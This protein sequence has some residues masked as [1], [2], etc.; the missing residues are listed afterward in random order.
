[1]TIFQRISHVAA[2]VV[3]ALLLG[4]NIVLSNMAAEDGMSFRVMA[5]YRWIFS[6][7]FLGPMARSSDE[8]L[9]KQFR[10]FEAAPHDSSGATAKKPPPDYCFSIGADAD[11][12]RIELLLSQVKGKDI[13]ELI[14]SGR[15]K[16]ALVP[17]GSGGAVA[18]AAL[19]GGAA[20]APAA[21]EK[22]KEKRNLMRTWASVSSIKGMLYRFLSE[23]LSIHKLSGKEKVLG[24]II[25][26]IGS[27]EKV[28]NDYPCHYTSTAWMSLMG[29]IQ[30]TIFGLCFERKSNQWKLGWSIRLFFVIYGAE[31]NEHR[32]EEYLKRDDP[33]TNSP[34][35][36][37]LVKIFSIYRY[38]VRMQC[39]G[40][41]DLTDPKVVDGIK[42][43]L[44]GVITI[45]RKIIFEGGLVAV[46]DGSGSGSGSGVAVGTN[47]A[48]LTIFETTNHYDYDHTSCTY[49]ATSSKCSACKCQDCK[50][51]HDGVINAINALTASVKEMTSKMGVIPS[52]RI[53]YPYTPLEIKEAKRRRKDTSKALL[54]IEKSKIV[55]PLSLFCIDVQ[56][57]RATREKHEPKKVVEATTEEH[58]ITV[59]N[60]STTFKKEENVE[61]V[62]SGE[63]KNYP[64]EGFNISDEAPKKLTQLINNYSEWIADELLKHHAGRNCGPFVAAYAEYLSDGLQVSNDGLDAGL[65]RKRY[66]ALLWKYGKAK[67]QNLYASDTRDPR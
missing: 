51:K 6:T 33:N 24:T 55:M 32:E 38:P 11:D 29:Y 20:A 60:L 22:K 48:P 52:K 41:I 25:C 15:K 36:E 14:T 18:V 57:A 53:S 9:T 23:Q 26:V 43:K 19:A 54:S 2:M 44:F 50:A 7:A 59:Y 31:D 35:S 1:M 40:A 39:D 10:M 42:I 17:A 30:S 66:A 61:A 47:D 62:S 34:S 3:V 56:C 21:E 28:G 67:S 45:K 63:R 16:L 58:N 5:A 4:G 8:N 27:M 65:L 64:F 12:D 37:E 49:F 13:T 46:D